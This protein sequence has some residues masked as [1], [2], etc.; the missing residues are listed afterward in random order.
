MKRA[1][2]LCLV[3][4]MLVGSPAG[5]TGLP[6]QPEDVISPAEPTPTPEPTDMPDYAAYRALYAAVA[7]PGG[8]ISPDMAAAQPS[9]E[10]VCSRTEDGGLVLPEET[11]QVT[12]SFAVQEA[13]LYC[14]ELVYTSGE[15]RHSKVSFSAI[16]DGLTPYT[17]W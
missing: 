6:A 8:E 3:L 14:L 13:G 2:A 5:A 1:L 9:A 16:L 15:T 10:T 4:L 17:E 7:A 11:G 12:W